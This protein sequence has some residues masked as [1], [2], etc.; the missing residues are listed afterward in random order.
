MDKELI[1][2]IRAVLQMNQNEFSKFLGVNRSELANV[3]AGYR[4]ASDRLIEAIYS[5]FDRG[6]IKKIEEVFLHGYKVMLEMREK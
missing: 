5:K 2:G 3:E 1:K 4:E 6:F